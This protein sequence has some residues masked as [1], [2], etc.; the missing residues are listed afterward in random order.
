MAVEDLRP[1]QLHDLTFLFADV[2]RS[3]EAWLTRSL[4]MT[5]CIPAV[6][7]AVEE[8]GEA[9]G[10]VVFAREGDGRAVYFHDAA[11]ALQAAVDAQVRIAN[12]PVETG[13]LRVR[14]GLHSGTVFQLSDG[15]LGGT[16]LNYSGRLHSCLLYTSPSPRDAT[17]SRMPSSA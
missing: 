17:L 8:A 2:E 9:K 5:T 7:A 6:N 12:S 10:G 13:G 14:I 16:P 3:S 11:A 1:D 15:D 4:E